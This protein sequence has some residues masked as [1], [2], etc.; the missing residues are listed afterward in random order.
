M[1]LAGDRYPICKGRASA[2]SW[3]TSSCITSSISGF[4]NGAA[5]RSRLGLDRALCRRLRDG[6]ESAGDARRILA[7]LKHRL[8]KFGLS[9][10]EDKTRLIAF[11][12]LPAMARQQR[13]EARVPPSRHALNCCLWVRDLR[14][15]GSPSAARAVAKF[16]K[17]A[18]PPVTDPGGAADPARAAH[19]HLDRH[20]ATTPHRRTRQEPR[21]IS[22]LQ[23]A[24]QANEHSSPLVTQ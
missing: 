5:A 16:Q 17:P 23:R 15:G 8:A 24:A 3:P 19:L 22:M 14:E 12:R 11:G 13:G 21:P 20:D 1:A 9:L 18:L 2:R 6:F 10:H 7:D 4:T